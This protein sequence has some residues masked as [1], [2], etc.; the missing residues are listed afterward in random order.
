MKRTAAV[1][2]CLLAFSASAIPLTAEQ[3]GSQKKRY[4]VTVEGTNCWA[5]QVNG[6]AQAL[7]AP[8]CH[9]MRLCESAPLVPPAGATLESGC[10][11]H[12]A[13]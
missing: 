13:L 9:D 2:L 12:L 4:V 7:G 3:N 11:R 6:G 10:D 1:L 5:Q 8:S